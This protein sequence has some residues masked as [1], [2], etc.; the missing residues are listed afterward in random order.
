MARRWAGQSVYK[1][2]PV[3]RLLLEACRTGDEVDIIYFGG[4]TPG[5]SRVICPRRLF[6]V[7]GYDS[8]YVEAYC[9][10]RGADRGFRLDK[11]KL[12][13]PK[14][15]ATPTHAATTSRQ[16]AQSSSRTSTGSGC[17]I[18]VIATILSAIIL[19]AI[20]FGAIGT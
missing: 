6:R 13:Y 12:S 18:Y 8:I 7:K 2:S 5:S 17:L 19:L 16:T 4:S 9:R 11:I 14:Y 15:V 3:A 20:V 10:T 1:Q